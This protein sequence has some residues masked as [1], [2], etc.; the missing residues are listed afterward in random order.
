[1]G[2]F[3]S[4]YDE[5]GD[6]WQTK[7]F[8]RTLR[9][10]GIG[11]RIEGPV[12]GDWQ[13]EVFGGPIGQP[14]R[15][16]YATIRDGHLDAVGVE[17]D[18]ALPLVDYNDYRIY[19]ARVRRERDDARQQVADLRAGIEREIRHMLAVPDDVRREREGIANDLRALLAGSGEQPGDAHRMIGGSHERPR[20]PECICGA[21][22]DRPNG[23]AAGL[24]GGLRP[25]PLPKGHAMTT[26]ERQTWRERLDPFAAAY[27]HVTDAVLTMSDDELRKTL[28]ATK[29]P[30]QTNSWWAAYRVAPIVADAVRDEQRRRRAEKA[31]KLK[32]GDT[33]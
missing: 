4:M 28:A 5:G 15:A 21:G 10:W 25:H 17:R 8:G 7:A 2:M 13:V 1:M 26:S 24:R 3:D 22:W 32:N 12:D 9:R 19:V 27:A 11:D 30:T 16:A 29:R 31:M 14:A 18:A 23:P 33:L 20:G 6:E